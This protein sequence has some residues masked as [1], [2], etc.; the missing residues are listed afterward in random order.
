[1]KKNTK[2]VKRIAVS[3][4]DHFT[5]GEKEYFRHLQGGIKLSGIIIASVAVALLVL[6]VFNLYQAFILGA[7]NNL[8]MSA[9]LKMFFTGIRNEHFYSAYKIKIINH[10]TLASLNILL[11]ILLGTFYH[12]IN[13][14][15]K[16]LAKCW[17][18]IEKTRTNKNI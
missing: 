12:F 6:S 10:M 5:S 2:K 1:M 3:L 14:E 17:R 11:I 8:S 13:R 7:E 18:V 16:L 9:V 15:E 4:T